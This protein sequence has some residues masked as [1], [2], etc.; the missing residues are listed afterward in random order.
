MKTSKAGETNLK[1]ADK[2]LQTRFIEKQAKV[3][4]DTY[5]KFFLSNSSNYCVVPLAILF[6]LLTEG[7]ITVYYRFLA[8]FD[9]VLS[10]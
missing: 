3:S 6:L 4:S 5:K 9:K 1:K 10:G 7:I 2:I 8:D